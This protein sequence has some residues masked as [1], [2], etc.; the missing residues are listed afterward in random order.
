LQV[1]GVKQLGALQAKLLAA[2][3]ED[4][5]VVL[6][7]RQ[8]GSPDSQFVTLMKWLVYGDEYHTGGCL[9]TS[10]AMG[11]GSLLIFLT[12]PGLIALSSLRGAG[13]KQRFIES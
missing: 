10:P 11:V 5:Q 7:D 1:P 6:R 3:Q 2:P 13:E 12:S 4:G 9:L 8:Q